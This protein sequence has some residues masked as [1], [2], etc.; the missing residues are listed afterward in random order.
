VVPAANLTVVTPVPRL[1]AAAGPAGGFTA[2]LPVLVPV[3]AATKLFGELGQRI[4]QPAVLG[5][6][7]AG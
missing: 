1:L 3:I 5:E 6:L 7:I 4:G 2:L